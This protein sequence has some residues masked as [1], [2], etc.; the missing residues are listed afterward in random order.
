[1]LRYISH[2]Y[3]YTLKYFCKGLKHYINM[4]YRTMLMV[5]IVVV[6]SIA[7]HSAILSCC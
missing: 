7:V 2:V 5:A 3:C 1:M 6:V 4:L